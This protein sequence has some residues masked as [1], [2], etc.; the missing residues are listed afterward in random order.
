MGL[1]S[2]LLLVCLGTKYSHHCTNSYCTIHKLLMLHPHAVHYRIHCFFLGGEVTCWLMLAIS[3]FYGQ[4]ITK[5]CCLDSHF[6]RII[7]AQCNYLLF[8]W[9]DPM[10]VQITMYAL[11]ASKGLRRQ[12]VTMNRSFSIGSVG[13][14]YQE[15]FLHI[16]VQFQNF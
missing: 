15:F 10:D 12:K 9:V 14:W 8:Y 13:A 1:R 7:T 16:D 4:I 11:L 3:M 2:C 6:S 5:L